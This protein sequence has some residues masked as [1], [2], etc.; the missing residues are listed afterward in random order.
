MTL[1][2][3]VGVVTQA[4]IAIGVVAN[5]VQSVMNGLKIETVHKA[6]NSMKD[7][8]VEAVRKEAFQAGQINQSGQ[9]DSSKV[10]SQ[11]ATT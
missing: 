4:L 5:V 7:E 8:L 6:T 3:G 9:Q 2:E 10:T 11:K 1:M